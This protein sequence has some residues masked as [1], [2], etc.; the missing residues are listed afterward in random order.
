[1]DRLLGA[2]ITR[3]KRRGLA[4][5]PL[6]LA[7]AGAAWLVRRGR[8]Q[9]KRPLWSGRLAPGERLQISVREPGAA[10]SAATSGE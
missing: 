2:L 10:E 6:W 8:N 1:M 3:A 4:G 7:V 9:P 5:E